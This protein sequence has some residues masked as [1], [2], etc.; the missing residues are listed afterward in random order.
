MRSNT[1]NYFILILGFTD[2]MLSKKKKRPLKIKA[3]IF[4]PSN[5][6]NTIFLI[7]N[8]L[9]DDGA[10]PS[11]NSCPLYIYIRTG[12]IRRKSTIIYIY[13]YIQYI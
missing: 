7:F 5:I 6:F 10:F 9:M 11:Y 8:Y 1:I 12:V 2:E 3:L 13:I 4:E